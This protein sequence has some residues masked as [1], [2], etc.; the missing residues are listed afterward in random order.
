MDNNIAQAKYLQQLV[1]D[2]SKFESATDPQMSAVCIRYL[3]DEFTDEQLTKLHHETA[4][5]IEKG[6]Q[7]WF[8]TTQMKGKTW[9]RINPVNIHTKIEHMK[10]LYQVLKKTCEAVKEEM[11]NVMTKSVAS[12]ALNE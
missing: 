9:F 3:A 1:M 2:D 10:A 5:R 4:S 8:A 12:K 6:G 7:F 11:Q